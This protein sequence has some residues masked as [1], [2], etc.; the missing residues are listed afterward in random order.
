MKYRGFLLLLIS[1]L[2]VASVLITAGRLK[3]A[4]A[5]MQDRDKDLVTLISQVEVS[6]A[7]LENVQISS[8]QVDSLLAFRDTERD[9]ANL[10]D[11]P[12]QKAV[13]Q[14]RV[15]PE[16]SKARNPNVSLHKYQ[17]RMVFISSIDRYA[18][19]D[20]YFVREGD[21]LPDNSKVVKI[22]QGKVLIKKSGVLQTAVVPK[23]MPISIQ[24]GM[25]HDL[26]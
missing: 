14:E 15:T 17:T 1:L 13:S 5:L 25:K 19:V 2:S 21:L 20:G 4:S 18:V 16:I 22:S 24:A 23:S 7:E 3:P 10:I 8:R 26:P 9:Y 6:P 12:P 11:I